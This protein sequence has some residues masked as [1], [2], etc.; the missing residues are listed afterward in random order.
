MVQTELAD[1]L[2]KHEETGNAES[3]RRIG[4]EILDRGNALLIFS[5]PDFGAG[6]NFACRVRSDESHI[7]ILVDDL[8][9]W[10]T[11][12][13]VA[14]HVRVSPL[15]RPANLARLL[16]QRGFVST[17]RETQ[18]VLAGVDAERPAGSNGRVTIGQIE[19]HEVD[20]WVEIQHR[21]FGM[22]A[23]SRDAL[24]LAHAT[25]DFGGIRPHL[26]RLD[27][28][29]V[30][31]GKLIEWQG[32]FGIYGVAVLPQAR[33]CGVGTA[34]VRQMIRDARQRGNARAHVDAPICLQ[35]ETGADT[36][37]W[38]ERLGFRVVYD[39]T[40][41]TLEKSKSESKNGNA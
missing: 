40:G 35:A 38:Y 12:H 39:R 5:R 4:G 18:M 8:C 24:D 14:P 31:A 17:E 13:G 6:L 10:F 23:P 16:E 2:E 26:A 33:G 15:T 27:C 11:R 36:Q 19:D 21:G 34:L 22:G 30:G 3:A 41:W 37:R 20:R 32:V 25:I 9:G 7:E 29:P 28:E 1:R